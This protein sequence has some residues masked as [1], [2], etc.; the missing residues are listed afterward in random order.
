VLSTA[1]LGS[2]LALTL[3][4]SRKPTFT[5]VAELKDLIDTIGVLGAACEIG[6]TVILIYYL[7]MS[8]SGFSRSESIIKKLILFTLSTGLLTSFCTLATIIALSLA[9]TKLIYN[10][11]FV[12]LSKLL[13]N[14]LFATLNARDAIQKRSPFRSDGTSLAHHVERERPVQAVEGGVRKDWLRAVISVGKRMPPGPVTK[15]P[16]LGRPWSKQ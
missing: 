9:P 6:I 3:D 11:F 16:A 1:W 7:L 13:S 8:R 5:R 2:L 12:N 4:L 15:N 14:S 10:L